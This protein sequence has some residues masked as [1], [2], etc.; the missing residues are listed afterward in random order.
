MNQAA[1][2]TNQTTNG[3]DKQLR[4]TP[5]SND[6]F[7]RVY[8]NAFTGGLVKELK[9]QRW[10]TLQAI[11]SYMDENG[12]CFP[13]QEQ[14]AERIGWLVQNVN[15]WV[16]ELEQF[17]WQGQ[18]ILERQFKFNGFS[19][20]TIYRI[21][22]LAQIAIFN[23]EVDNLTAPNVKDDCQEPSSAAGELPNS[24]NVEDQSST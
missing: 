14:L 9:P 10:T 21:L 3:G 15:K 4:E 16:Q 1:N 17:R 24:M 11:A 22:P 12:Y 8:I 19:K 18:P 5:K 7:F 20:Y 13:T 23:G 6:L 2:A